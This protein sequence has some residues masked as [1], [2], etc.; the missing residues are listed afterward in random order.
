MSSKLVAEVQAVLDAVAHAPPPSCSGGG[1]WEAMHGDMSGFFEVRVRGDGKNHRVFCVLERDA[2][3]LG[4]PSI[5]VIDGLFTPKRSAAKPKDYRG[6]LTMR[7][8]WEC[9]RTVLE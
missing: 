2:A 3:D 9:R 7:A 6:A 8:E 4:G 1:K 5:V